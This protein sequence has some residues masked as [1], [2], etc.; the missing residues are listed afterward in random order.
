MVIH[1]MYQD[2]WTHHYLKFQKNE[3]GVPC[4]PMNPTTSFYVKNRTRLYCT[5]LHPNQFSQENEAQSRHKE[6][7]WKVSP[8]IKKLNINLNVK[9]P[10]ARTRSEPFLEM[11]SRRAPI[12]TYCNY[13][14][15]KVS[16]NI[17]AMQVKETR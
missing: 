7:I 4:S 12:Q 17:N 15:L 3:H 5:N 9:H 10:V 13:R 6:E 16:M 14:N 2:F 1:E 8:V 11:V